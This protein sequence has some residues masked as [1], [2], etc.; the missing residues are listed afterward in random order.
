MWKELLLLLKA[1][2]QFP[3]A[4]SLFPWMKLKIA[5]QILTKKSR[6]IMNLDTPFCKKNEASQ[7][8]KKKKKKKKI[9]ISARLNKLMLDR[10]REKEKGLSCTIQSKGKFRIVSLPERI[11]EEENLMTKPAA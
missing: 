8:K 3:R 6:C 4:M 7:K 2:F 10:W 9:I 5:F 1:N 11:E